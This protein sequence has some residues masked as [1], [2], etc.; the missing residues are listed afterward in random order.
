MVV[1]NGVLSIP[2]VIFCDLCF[3]LILILLLHDVGKLLDLFVGI[4]SSSELGG[5]IQLF[6][7]FFDFGLLIFERLDFLLQ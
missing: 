5:I 4:Y 6:L 1:L 3:E 7:E 2:I